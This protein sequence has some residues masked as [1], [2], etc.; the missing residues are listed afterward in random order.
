MTTHHT[1]ERG[2]VHFGTL[3][4][5]TPQARALDAIGAAVPALEAALGFPLSVTAQ[6]TED[7]FILL[8][9]LVPDE[10]WNFDTTRQIGKALRDAAQPFTEFVLVDVDS[11]MSYEQ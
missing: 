7:G 3:D 11:D 9:I 4:A 10:H 1:D 5:R 8:H 2:R 6:T